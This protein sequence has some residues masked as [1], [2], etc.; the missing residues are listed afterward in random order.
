MTI[1][2]IE[3]PPLLAKAARE[4]RTHIVAAAMFSLG[5]NLLYLAAPIYMLQVYDRVVPTG[6]V[7]TLGFITLALAI[8]L[9]SLSMLDA[10]RLRLLVRASLRIDALVTPRLLQKAVAGT[11]PAQSIRDLDTVRSTLASPAAA[12]LL[13]LPWL[14]LFII[15]SFL[16]NVWIGVLAVVAAVAMFALAWANQRLTRPAMDSATTSLAAAHNWTQAA[17]M[18]G[19][20]VRALGMGSRVA[21]LGLSKRSSAVEQ[22]ASAQFAGSRFTA[23]GRFL[24]LFVQSA[25]LGLGALLAIAGDLSAGAIIASSIVV[26]RALQPVDALIAGWS[27]LT[28]AHAA[29]ARLSKAVESEPV[30]QEVRTRLPDPEGRLSVVQVGVRTADGRPI[31]FGVSFEVVPGEVVAVIGPSGSGKTTLARILV[32]AAAPTVGEVRIDGARLTDWQADELGRHIGYMPQQ[33]SLLEGSI[34]DN[35]C[36]FA[37]GPRDSVD[38]E[39]VTAAKLAGV[40]ELILHLPD[41]YETELGPLGAG[42]SAGQG[43][44]IALARALYGSPALLVL[45]EPNSWLDS[46]GDIALAKAVTAVRSRGGGVVIAAHRKSVLDYADRVLLLDSGR[47]R[48]LGE[49]RKVVAQLTGTKKSETAA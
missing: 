18:Q 47:P 36:R 49:T 43:Q 38:A 15:V 30:V 28:G 5:V 20:S 41:G 22:L 33:P 12:A 34:R 3:L 7:A 17:T 29:L 42:L 40:H 39:V 31:L 11:G 37:E 10:I 44:R 46:D 1:A 6:G 48:L 35:I 25:A 32:G 2:G 21:R 23:A 45:D 19:D 14:P 26:G 4:C 13:D 24:R 27:S 16:L 9:V 8:A